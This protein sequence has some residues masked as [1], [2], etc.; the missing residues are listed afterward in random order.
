MMKNIQS[1][2]KFYE[3]SIRKWIKNEIEKIN[4]LQWMA[5]HLAIWPERYQDAL[6]YE[7]KA[8][9]EQRKLDQWLE[10]FPPI[11]I[12]FAHFNRSRNDIFNPLTD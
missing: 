12:P 1:N 2:L 9:D 11:R 4:N 6:N 7:Q 5:R 10:D 8:K 3:P